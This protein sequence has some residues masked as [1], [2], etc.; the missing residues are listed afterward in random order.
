MRRRC[1]RL[2]ALGTAA[3][4]CAGAAAQYPNQYPPGQYPP[5]QYPPGQYPPGQYPQDP[6][7]Y[8]GSRMPGGIPMPPIKWPKRGPK[9]GS[10]KGDVQKF[11]GTLRKLAEKELVIEN[12]GEGLLR[13]RLLAKTQFRDKKGDT[14]RDS[15]LK[16]GDQLEVQTDSEDPETARKVVLLRTGTEEERAA[17]SKP[18]ESPA[19]AAAPPADATPATATP[20][21]AKPEA[22]PPAAKAP[23]PRPEPADDPVIE[24][25]R[26]AAGKFSASLPDYLV[27][28]VT[29]RLTSFNNEASWNT[30]D[31]I[32]AEVASVKGKEEY[33]N[34]RVNGQPATRAPEQSGTWSTG[35]FVSTL[36]DILS[37]STAAVFRPAGQER[38]GSRL[39]QLYDYSVT[40]DNSHWTLVAE[41]GRRLSP[42]Y[43]GQLWID[44]ETRRVLRIEQRAVQIPA[45]F[46]QDKAECVIEYGFVSIGDARALLPAKAETTGCRRGTVNCS[47]NITEFRNY[48]RFAAESSLKFD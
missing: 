24:A 28:Q 8:P 47:K 40:A 6:Y 29:T 3:L 46:P 37:P 45:T 38:V 5:G 9:E 18:I 33:R 7:P 16:P 11:E 13:F 19:P 44:R 31:V 27:E 26:E 23:A 21:P 17:A 36:E 4:L 39:A 42:A 12:S 34:I 14:L 1:V 32:T 43:K 22:P 30:L 35:E 2:A 20:A 10:K 15:L 41:D 25:A 48:R